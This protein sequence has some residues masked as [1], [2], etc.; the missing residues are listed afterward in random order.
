MTAEGTAVGRAP[1]VRARF[2]EIAVGFAIQGAILFAG[3]GR[4]DWGWAWLYLG[5][6]TAAVAVNA[7]ILL[8]HSP[9][10]IVE[11]SRFGSMRRWDRDV[12]VAW[13]VFAYVVLPLVAALD[14]RWGWSAA[15]AL[16][17]RIAAGAGLAAT[18]AL[19]GW[20]MAANAFFATQVRI[21]TE[22]GHTVCTSGPYR[23]VRHPGYV[24]FI[25]QGFATALLLG[26]FWALVPAAAA[27]ALMVVRTALED[28]T[29]R[30]E[31]AGYPEYAVE[32]RW[33]LVP[34][35]W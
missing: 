21:Q 25:L 1:G 33:R 11:R 23:F 17:W 29:L 5:I 34:G 31:L 8:R 2:V 30:A 22:R 20:A 10:L 3:A 16:P 14:A 15:L 27:G 4:L 12:S 7:T 13:S 28:R 26:S 32:V 35:V 19:A 18:F 9:D 6:C 24:G